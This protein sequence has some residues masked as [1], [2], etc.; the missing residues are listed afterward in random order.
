MK[1][2]YECAILITFSE[3]LNISR[4]FEMYHFA[5]LFQWHLICD[6]TYVS[7]LITSVQM[8]GVLCGAMIT[9]Q[10]ADVFGRKKVLFGNYALLLMFWFAS[11]FSNSWPLYCALRFIIGGL[12]GGK[13]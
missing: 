2:I 9:G 5:L 11:S 7:T 10:L 13:V 8:A 6:Q 3:M 4:N 1:S 12:V